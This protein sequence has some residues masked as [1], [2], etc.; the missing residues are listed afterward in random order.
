MS[1]LLSDYFKEIAYKKLTE[2]EANP[3]ISHQHE[4]NGIVALKKMFGISRRDLNVLQIYFDDRSD[5]LQAKS[6][7]TWYDAR[8]NHPER[9]EHRLY[10]KS[11]EVTI[12]VKP[13]DLMVIAQRPDGNFLNIFAVAGSSAENQI[14]TLFGITEVTERLTVHD[15]SGKY[16][17][18]IDIVRDIILDQLG[19]PEEEPPIRSADN[20]VEVM[21]KKFP[22]GL[23]STKQF[24]Q[25][26]R[27][28][29]PEV[30]SVDPDYA[31][32]AWWSRETELFKLYEKHLFEDQKKSLESGD[33][34]SF[35]NLSLSIQ[36]RRKSRAGQALENHVE[37]IFTDHKLSYSRTEVTENNSKPDFVFPGIEQ[38][39]DPI[40]PSDRLYMLG[41]KTTCKDRWRQVLAEAVRISDKHLFTLEPAISQNQT[42]EMRINKLTLVLPKDIQ[43]S[44]TEKQRKNILSL[45]EFIV[46]VK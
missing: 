8:E 1:I 18:Q 21:M 32:L 36:N 46:L 4:F 24:S 38:Y 41:V 25:F 45:K 26:A 37:K 27:E 16:D 44:Y 40:F 39:R 17:E 2:V 9:T 7:M 6:Q 33:I 5:P 34:D 43:S 11:S 20:F 42:D 15:I 22:K 13:G 30:S 35:I 14:K 23:P 12:K 29:L 19:I 28:T 10:Y 3:K 31:I